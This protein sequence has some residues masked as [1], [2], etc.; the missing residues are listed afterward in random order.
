MIAGPG[1]VRSRAHLHTPLQALGRW[2]EEYIPEVL[3]A[4]EA[5]DARQ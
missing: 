1:R 4:R 2:A 3:A 5:Y